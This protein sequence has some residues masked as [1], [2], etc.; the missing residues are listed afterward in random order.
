MTRHNDNVITM[1]DSNEF[2]LTKRE[3]FAAMAMH[4]M[5]SD[6]SQRNT[7]TDRAR[8]SVKISDILIDELNK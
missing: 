8:L 1:S 3:L 4:G 7:F 5:L 6:S 2:G